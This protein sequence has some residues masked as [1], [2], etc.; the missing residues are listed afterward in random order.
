MPQ[1]PGQNQIKLKKAIQ[2]KRLLYLKAWI[3]SEKGRECILA[4]QQL[5]AFTI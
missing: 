1:N 4:I 2:Q 3:Q 5:K